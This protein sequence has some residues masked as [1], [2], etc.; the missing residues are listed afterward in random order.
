M[1]A[2][3]E[4]L[5]RLQGFADR[6]QYLHQNV[7]K[8]GRINPPLQALLHDLRRAFEDA[9]SDDLNMPEALAAIHTFITDC[10]KL[11]EKSPWAQS[12]TQAIIEQFRELDRVVGLNLL[13]GKTIENIPDDIQALVLA[14]E[15]ARRDRDFQRADLLRAQ[16]EQQG[17]L[18]EDQPHGSRLKKV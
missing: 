10:Y 6:V 18:L 7:P 16:I 4:G 13:E 1:S 2:A 14:R 9:A 8:N 3:Q 5:A 11:L 12:D 15:E 17:F